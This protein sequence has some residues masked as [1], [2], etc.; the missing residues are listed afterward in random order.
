MENKLAELPKNELL[1]RATS[2]Q[3]SIRRERN[4]SE[5]L[6]DKVLNTLG[7]VTAAAT[8]FG[9]GYLEA[10]VRNKDGTPMSVGP[11]P[12]ALAAGGALSLT[13]LF[14]DPAGQVSAAACGALGAYGST[15][16]RGYAMKAAASAPR[17]SGEQIVGWSDEEAALL[18]G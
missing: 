8:G 15:V 10:K 16:G 9:I 11:V 1:R 4:R 18:N 13:A 12:L 14:F 5:A 6:G 3:A 17:V 7:G 2:L